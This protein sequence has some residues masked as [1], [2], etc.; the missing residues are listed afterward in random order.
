MELSDNYQYKSYL[1]MKKTKEQ[2]YG[3]K[4]KDI[5]VAKYVK[6][7]YNKT[8]LGNNEK[9]FTHNTVENIIRSLDTVDD[10][11]QK[12][13]IIQK[14]IDSKQQ[15]SLGRKLIKIICCSIGYFK[16]KKFKIKGEYK[17]DYYYRVINLTH[18]NYKDLV[19]LDNIINI[20]L[21][22]KNKFKFNVNFNCR[23]KKSPI[24]IKVDLQKLK[25]K[26]SEI[27]EKKKNNFRIK[28]NKDFITELIKEKTQNIVR[29][30]NEFENN[31]KNGVIENEW[32]NEKDRL[33]SEFEINI[34][35]YISEYINNQLKSNTISIVNLYEKIYGAIG[36]YIKNL[37]TSKTHTGVTN[38]REIP[39]ISIHPFKFDNESFILIY[40]S[41]YKITEIHV[42]I[43]KN[44]DDGEKNE[45]YKLVFIFD[46][47]DI[48]NIKLLDKIDDY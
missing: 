34:N 3:S 46:C 21:I 38:S 12:Y 20:F 25:E 37:K 23:V 8:P 16:K 41:L 26:I 47:R 2:I 15:K 22:F 7:K 32:K 28:E 11:S 9:L 36:E 43:I 42:N 5:Q 24:I 19:Y 31:V 10:L 40:N 1:T 29:V 4:F 13:A 27:I 30:L 14:N 45:S 17:S 39:Q 33:K 48:E 44:I 6:P 18:Y 35:D